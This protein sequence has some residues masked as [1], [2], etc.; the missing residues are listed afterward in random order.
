[1]KRAK[2]Y[3]NA[4]PTFISFQENGWLVENVQRPFVCFYCA[5]NNKNIN[6]QIV[7]L[8]SVLFRSFGYHIA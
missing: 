4:P 7:F 5:I 6:K 8:D 3:D 2:K 1:M